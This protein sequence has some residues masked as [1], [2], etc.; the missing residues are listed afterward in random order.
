[1]RR[2]RD[3][4][5]RSQGSERESRVDV[6]PLCPSKPDGHSKVSLRARAPAFSGLEFNPGIAYA[7]TGCLLC[8]PITGL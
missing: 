5:G 6:T 2:G 8:H 3:I 4:A 7:F 1:M